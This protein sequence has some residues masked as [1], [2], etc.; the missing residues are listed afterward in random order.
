MEDIEKVRAWA[1]AKKLDEH[2]ADQL[3][4]NGFN[5]MESLS[6]LTLEDIQT[7]DIPLGQE[8]M[9]MHAVD[10]TF[11]KET[12][13]SGA[14]NMAPNDA[15]PQSDMR[16]GSSITGSGLD[17][18]PHQRDGDD[19]Y[20][21]A[22]MDQLKTNQLSATVLP[23]TSQNGT[24][25]GT[26]PGVSNI[27]SWLDP[28]LCLKSVPIVDSKHLD[29][30]DFVCSNVFQSDINNESL[31]FSGKWGQLV[32][33]SG[34]V[35]PKL[36]SIT[37]CQWSMANI[38]I[39]Y[40][41]LETGALNPQNYLD[42]MSYSKRIYQ[43]I[44]CYDMVS[45]FFYDREY[46]CLQHQHKFRW[47]TDVPHLQTVFLRPRFQQ[48]NYN[49]VNMS[50][51]SK[52][53][54]KGNTKP[55]GYAS[56]THAGKEICRWFNGRRGCQ[57]TFCK[58]EHICSVPG[59]NRDSAQ[60]HSSGGP[61]KN[62]GSGGGGFHDLDWFY[63]NW[64]QDF[65]GCSSFHINELEAFSVILAAK[66]WSS[67]WENKRVIVLCDNMATVAFINKC[68]SRN[69]ILMGFLREVFWLSASFNFH[70]KAVHVPGSSNVLADHISR[71]QESII[72]IKQLEYQNSIE[73]D[74][75]P[76]V[77]EVNLEN[78][79]GRW[80]KD[81]QELKPSEAISI[82]TVGKI[83][84]LVIHSVTAND[85]GNYTCHITNKNSSAQLTVSEVS[86]IKPI[87]EQQ[88]H[89][90]GDKVTFTCEVN[91]DVLPGTWF[92]NGKELNCSDYLDIIANGR[93]REIVIHRV[94]V[95]DRG[96]YSFKI[97]GKTSGGLLVVLDEFTPDRINYIRLYH[98]LETVAEPVVR[99]I[100]DCEIHP[101][102]LK[103]ILNKNSNKIHYLK[104]HKHIN[105]REYDLLYPRRAE[106]SVKFEIKN[107]DCKRI[108]QNKEEDSK[109]K[110]EIEC[111]VLDLYSNV[112]G[113]HKVKVVAFES[114]SLIVILQL[115]STSDEN[116]LNKILKTAVYKGKVGAFETES[117]GFR[118]TR[119][120]SK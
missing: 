55:T 92:K 4:K 31:I 118:F 81:G 23:E 72:F 89:I 84:I 75:V 73:G 82:T 59:C 70:I 105:M 61:S 22:L 12:Q 116:N 117:T 62:S 16:A 77:C 5:S 119:L 14:S 109:L 98:L 60:S 49:N 110:A 46:R 103:K 97:A 26:V 18:H 7:F 20:I 102:Q 34:P 52:S 36:E 27:F 32:F 41:L 10:K 35:K 106:Y 76:F 94:T 39:M 93:I 33:K 53:W 9:L 64:E 78:I 120:G 38:S 2:T 114:C 85:S 1:T 87:E 90:E 80:S 63:V 44:T 54:G 3:L 91:S 100:F 71:L 48:P 101:N 56:Y 74:R 113:D 69:K 58:F 42:Y 50:N 15:E 25:Q 37:L 83:H 24:Q 40:K 28:Q 11:V 51:N 6:L 107:Y 67:S 43:L 108:H 86:I 65:P 68:T 115:I 95:D 45:V 17:V 19:P 57:S 47:C 13:V 29:I 99:K 66:R 30:I 79:P 111:A 88:Q 112:E 8:K 96:Y 104:L 21:R